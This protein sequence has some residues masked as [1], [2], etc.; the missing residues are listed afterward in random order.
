MMI[1]NKGEESWGSGIIAIKRTHAIDGKIKLIR[2][3]RHHGG[4]RVPRVRKWVRSDMNRP[5]QVMEQQSDLREGFENRSQMDVE[6]PPRMD[7]TRRRRGE[8]TL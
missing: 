6:N 5:Q 8:C 1:N 7:I 4:G 3:R 2:M